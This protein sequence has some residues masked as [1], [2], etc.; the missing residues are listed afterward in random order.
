MRAMRLFIFG[1][2]TMMGGLLH[3]RIRITK[4]ISTIERLRSRMV[5]LA[6]NK[7]SAMLRGFV[8]MK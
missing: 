7:T 2:L 5:K 4:I 3:A 6:G 8:L 1:K